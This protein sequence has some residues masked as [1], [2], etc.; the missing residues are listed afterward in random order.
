MGTISEHLSRHEMAC[1]CGCGFDAC[2]VELIKVVEDCVTH[3]EKREDKRLVLIVTGPNRCEA[4]NAKTPGAVKNSPHTKAMA[5]DFTIK[6]IDNDDIADYLMAKYHT[7]YGIGRYVGR[8]HIDVLPGHARR[9][10]YR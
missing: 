7:K 6:G 3:F 10:D 8:T 4:H 9:W 2:D 1:N 5:M